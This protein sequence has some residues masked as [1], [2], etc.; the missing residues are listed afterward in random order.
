VVAAEVGHLE[1]AYDNLGETAFID[2]RRG[3]H[4]P[5]ATAKLDLMLAS[6]CRSGQSASRGAV[7]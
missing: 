5:G 2:R 7:R 6:G 4:R 1:L 3:A